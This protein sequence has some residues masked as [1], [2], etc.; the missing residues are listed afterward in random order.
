MSEQNNDQDSLPPE[1]IEALKSARKSVPVITARVD[2]EISAQATAQFGRRART[3]RY[4]GLAVAA[5]LMLAVFVALIREPQINSSIDPSADTFADLDASG[6]IDIA[7]VLYLARRN[8]DQ[9][10]IDQF[11]YRIVALNA[12]EEG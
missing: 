3:R 4:A 8:S 12:P 2:R 5:S 11:A 10:A 1:L 7:D 6:Q 9:D